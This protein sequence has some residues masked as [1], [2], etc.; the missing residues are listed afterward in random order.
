MDKIL[1]P[2]RLNRLLNTLF[3]SN[4]FVSYHYALVIYLNSSLLGK[5]FDD[6]Q[7]SALYIIGSII[8]VILLLNASKFMEKMGNYRLT[9]YAIIIEFLAVFGLFASS[10]PFLTA[11]YFIAHL[12]TISLLLFSMDIFVESVSCDESVTGSIRGT[13]LTL[14]N[15]MI[16]VAPLTISFLAKGDDYSLIYI[17]SA[18]LMFPL[19]L[20]IKKFKYVEQVKVHH[21]KIRETIGQYLRNKNLYNIFVAHTLLQL[22][23]GFMVIYTPIYLSKY[24]G[25]TWAE[26]GI[27]F[28]IM[29]LPFVIFE[30]PVGELEDEIY[31]EKEFLT[32]GFIIMGVTTLIISFITV[33]SF[34]I[35]AT[36][37]FITRIGASLVEVSTE[38]YFFKQVGKEQTD[39]VG[40][41]RISRPLALIL[42]PIIATVAL[43]FIPF[44]YIF[45]ILGT[46]MVVGTHYSLALKD[47]K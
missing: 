12:S 1:L 39:I 31:G 28:T 5:F 13:Y 19:Y 29:L 20:T 43:Q 25:F 14:T 16:V 35:W 47:S 8:N 34:W 36:L 2:F 26:M 7:I 15:I 6:T 44:Q 46:L 4:I 21:I 23:Y 41:F 10:T 18:L 33:K 17:I 32:I 45:I 30:A 24:I 42:S 3:L 38:S 22:F 27:I 9:V 37:L 11:V 40:L